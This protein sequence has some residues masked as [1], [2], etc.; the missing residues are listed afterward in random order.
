MVRS[1]VAS[2]SRAMHSYASSMLAPSKKHIS[3]HSVLADI[4]GAAFGN[5]LR[6]P[7][8]TINGNSHHSNTDADMG[9]MACREWPENADM[10]RHQ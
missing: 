10:A 8:I 7:S 5:A 6:T 4:A 2:L 9:L 3:A 1:W